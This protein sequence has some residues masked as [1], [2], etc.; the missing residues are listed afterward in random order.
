MM[1]AKPGSGNRGRL[2]R[3]KYPHIAAFLDLK[4]KMKAK[5]L[6][7]ETEKNRGV[8]GRDNLDDDEIYIFMHVNAHCGFHMHSVPFPVTIAFVDQ[9]FGIIDIKEM[10]PESGRASAPEGTVYA[11]EAT[12]NFYK[13]NN[14]KAGDFFKQLY[15]S[16]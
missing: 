16:L 3:K 5:I 7:T 15:L 2:D 1:Y 9:E 8:I 10:Q 14:L 4:S 6:A 11:V 12:S 13:N